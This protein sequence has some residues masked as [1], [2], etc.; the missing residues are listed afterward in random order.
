M[1]EKRMLISRAMRRPVR[2]SSKLV[3]DLF[4]A[5]DASDMTYGEVA[6]RSGVSNVTL[7][8]WKSGRALPRWAEME[9]VAQTIGYG[10]VVLPLSR[11]AE[12]SAGHSAQPGAQSAIPEE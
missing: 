6:A 10:F 1:G 7:A 3:H 9:Y 4:A 11:V 12:I 2:S 5:I 8:R